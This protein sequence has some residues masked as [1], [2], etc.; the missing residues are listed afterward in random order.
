MNVSQYAKLAK[1]DKREY[2]YY[3]LRMHDGETSIGEILPNSFVWI[4]GDW[5]EEELD[6]TCAVDL[7]NQKAEQLCSTYF[8]NAIVIAGNSASYG[9]DDGEIIICD[10]IRV[11]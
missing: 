5:T 3:G 10:A 9:E 4:D 1:S 6:G 2:E 8:G 7:R 11:A